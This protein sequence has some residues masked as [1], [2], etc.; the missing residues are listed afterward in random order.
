MRTFGKWLG[1]LLLLAI[2]AAG[3]FFVFA[4]GYVERSRNN[5]VVHEPYP[6]S[7]AA[8]ALHQT[9]VIGDWHA[10][11]LLWNRDLTK[12]GSYGQ[13]DLPRLQEGNVAV[14][15]FTAVTKSP[16]GQNY[17]SNSAETTDNITL[18][19]VG[20]LWPVRTWNSL[21]ERALYQAEKLHRFEAEA[22]RR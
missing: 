21:L 13:V 3:A 11:S 6:V 16:A 9:L 22:P 4:P 5:V 15:V 20:Q 14:Q 19:A 12:R 8:S 7:E 17:D 2:I 1:R 18:L 10:D